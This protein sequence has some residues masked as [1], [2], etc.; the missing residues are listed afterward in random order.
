METAVL[1]AGS[2]AATTTDDSSSSGRPSSRRSLMLELPR[3]FVAVAAPLALFAGLAATKGA[4]PLETYSAMFRSLM[5]VNSLAQVLVKSTPILLAALAVAVPARAG[6]V[7]VG[8]EGQLVVGA[9]AAYGSTLVVGDGVPGWIA[10]V[11]MIASAGV[12]GAL[13]ATIAMV[14]R[15]TVGIN[16]AVTTLLL[17]YIA[18]DI[19]AFLV[20]DRWKDRRGSGQPVSRALPT[21]EHLPIIGLDRVHLGLVFALVA[22]AAVA[23]IFQ[24]TT[25]GFRLR[26]IGGNA[27]AGRRAGYNV[28]LLLIVAMALGGA[29]AGIGGMT[30]LAGV[31]FKLRQGLVVQYGYI[32]YLASWLGRHRPMSIVF[33]TLLLSALAISGDS[34]QIDSQLP[35]ASVNILMAL[36]L[37]GVFGVG[38]AR[39]GAGKSARAKRARRSADLRSARAGAR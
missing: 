38:R 20:Y 5:T 37:L 24:F 26:V 32:A 28:S 25:L 17:N 31:E 1:D 36:L 7:N 13:W 19:M 14:L 23:L 33:S 10:I 22:L 39:T 34:L 3:W 6:L 30:Q 16:E 29:L 8:G 12:A 11:A 35:A 2:I 27:E 15:L 21:D 18:I 9:V 4:S